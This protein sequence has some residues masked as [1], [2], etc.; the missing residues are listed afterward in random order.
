MHISIPELFSNIIYVQI[1][2]EKQ[3]Q[4]KSITC[5]LKMF[6]NKMWGQDTHSHYRNLCW[7]Q[8]HNSLLYPTKQ[9]STSV[10]KP[11]ESAQL[12]DPHDKPCLHSSSVSQSP[13]F[14]SQGL[15]IVQ[16]LKLPKIG[17]KKCL[18]L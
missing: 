13:S 18:E 9:Q 14:T 15:L 16:E 12:F 11:R 5:G 2:I 6:F 10:S 7:Y 8:Y 17:M 4:I 3:K 1:Y